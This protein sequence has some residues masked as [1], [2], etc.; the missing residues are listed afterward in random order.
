MNEALAAMLDMLDHDALDELAR[1]LR[2]KLG[3]PRETPKQRRG[4]R[5]SFLGELVARHGTDLH[6]HVRR[7][8][9]DAERPEQSPSSESLVEEYGSWLKACRA[10]VGVRPDGRL[11][12]P[13]G[14]PRDPGSRVKTWAYSEEEFR[15]AI[16]ACARALGRLPTSNAYER[17][18]AGEIRKAR[19]GGAPVPRLPSGSAI[20]RN[21][22]TWRAAIAAAAVSEATLGDADPDQQTI[23]AAALPL[24]EAI[25]AARA[26]TVSLEQL[27]SL[28]VEPGAPPPAE[29]R[30]DAER[31]K[32]RLRE[33][34]IGERKLL[35]AVNLPLGP[36]R[37]LLSGTLDPPLELLVA[38]AGVVG[39][40]PSAL[41]TSA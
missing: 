40:P 8:L 14:K 15:D 4:R 9:Y 37:R 20:G 19:S 23:A 35:R 24:T 38:L 12:R 33:A 32:T 11:N 34:G 39:V 29:A 18:R 27:A 5:L 30:F 22:K 1:V 2:A 10:S 36:Y 16:R 28:T 3:P 13:G 31:W 21:L 17:W 26:A 6:P 7:L 41:L 25:A